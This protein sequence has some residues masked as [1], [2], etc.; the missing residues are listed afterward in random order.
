MDFGRASTFV[1][2]VDEPGVVEPAVR[3]LA[4]LRFTGLGEVEFKH[5]GR[6]GR[7][8]L[9]D[10]NPRIWGWISLCERAGVDFPY[11]LWLLIR[12]DAVP[13][14]RGAIGVKWMRMSTALPIAVREIRR[15]RLSLCT[16]VRSFRAPPRVRHLCSR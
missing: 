8:Q 9:L 7:F 15:G 2:T 11:L 10:V 5:D 14:V 13:E 1:E 4:T 3:L 12:G 6:D 16:Y